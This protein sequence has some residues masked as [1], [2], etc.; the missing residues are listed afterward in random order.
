MLPS[1]CLTAA[2]AAAAFAVAGCGGSHHDETTPTDDRADGPLVAAMMPNIPPYLYVVYSVL[3]ST[4][5]VD[6]IRMYGDLCVGNVLK[7]NK[8]VRE[9]TQWM[10]EDYGAVDLRA[11]VPD[12]ALALKKFRIGKGMDVEVAVNWK[13]QRGDNG[14]DASIDI[15]FTAS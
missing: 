11:D 10:K 7:A 8:M 3:P 9:I 5:Q 14:S 1:R 6:S 2:F 15:S 13:N 4:R 12:G